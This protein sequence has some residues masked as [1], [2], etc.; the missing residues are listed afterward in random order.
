MDSVPRDPRFLGLPARQG[1][2]NPDEEKDSCGLGV[3][4]SVIGERS[5]KIVSDAKALLCNMSA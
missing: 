2:Y 4:V 5:H 3:L 1:L